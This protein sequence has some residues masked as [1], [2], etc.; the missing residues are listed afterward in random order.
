[1]GSPTTFGHSR[2]VDPDKPRCRKHIHFEIGAPLLGGDLTGRYRT[3]DAEV[4]H[5]DV[6]VRQLAQQLGGAVRSTHVRRNTEDVTA[7][8]GDGF[9]D[10][11]GRTSIDGDA[12]PAVGEPSTIAKPMPCVDP[13][14]RAVFPVRSM[15]TPC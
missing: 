5:Q 14:T 1:L 12:R 7:Q 3:E 2:Q 9:L 6:D 10:T 13:V 11:R 15:F 4:V 8:F